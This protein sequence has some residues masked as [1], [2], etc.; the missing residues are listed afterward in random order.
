MR[1]KAADEVA[2]SLSAS[3]A[4]ILTSPRPTKTHPPLERLENA[5]RS[6]PQHLPDLGLEMEETFRHVRED[7]VPGL[8]QSSRSSRYYGFVTGGSTPAASLA[9][10]FV[11]AFD[12][13]VGVHL[14][15]ESVATDVEDRALSMLCELL[16]LEPLQWPH[17]TFTTGATASNVLGLSCGRE[18]IIKFASGDRNVSV[19]E[20]GI[21]EAMLQ[22]SINRIQI[23]TTAPHSSL[24]KAA[25]I[26]GLGRASVTSVGLPDAPHLFDLPLLKKLL[27]TPGTASIIAVSASEVNT[28]LYAT[29]GMR[30]MQ[31]LRELSDM[32]GAWIHVD[33]AFGIMGRL[34]T[35]PEDRNIIQCCE[36]LELADSITGDA[37][38]LL[39]VPYDCGFFLSRHREIAAQVFQNPNAAY[40]N[41]ASGDD[42]PSPL[43]IGLENSRRFRALPVYA[44]L[45]TYGRQGY[46]D[47]LERQIA[48]A[49][50]IAEMIHESQ[51][52]ELLPRSKRTKEDILD[53]IF[54]IVL[55]RAKSDDLNAVLV[56]KINASRQIYVSGTSWEGKSACRFAVSNWQADAK[57]DLPIIKQ[58]LTDIVT[59]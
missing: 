56:E 46:R 44:S 1:M 47:M 27:S 48:V 50:G 15:N 2:A 23:L 35:D 59:A 34:L 18:Y 42:I 24:S 20:I 25:S 40:L 37:H 33:G 51:D 16:N 39:N 12:Q 31:E 3:I 22:A 5:R 26:L 29:T 11:T 32:Y 49:R 6:L 14:P 45:L 36:G 19:G 9:D 30:Q 13:N 58:V 4:T 54:I 57:K 8:S 38:K 17:K 28:G 41:S 7:V 43:N 52:F 55:F 53:D 21:Y 10:N